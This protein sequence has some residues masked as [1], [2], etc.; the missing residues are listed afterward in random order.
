MIKEIMHHKEVIEME[1]ITNCVECEEL[2][3]KGKTH[4][5]MWCGKEDKK[6][7]QRSKNH[8]Y[9]NIL[10][11]AWCSK[12]DDCDEDYDDDYD[13]DYEECDECGENYNDCDCE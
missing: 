13:E 10:T 4:Q 7:V 5:D 6:I 12:N 8:V 11:P 3:V 2:R 9:Q 1:K